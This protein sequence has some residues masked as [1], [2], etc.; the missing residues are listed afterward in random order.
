LKGNEKYCA[1]NHQKAAMIGLKFI[2]EIIKFIAECR[3]NK[4]VDGLSSE[5]IWEL[6]K[7]PEKMR[8]VKELPKREQLSPSTSK[9]KKQSK[10]KRLR[11]H[12][13]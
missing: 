9:S 6:E 5:Q 13:G 2:S 3:Y 10:S 12:Y 11:C 1:D 8:N 4:G 7:Q